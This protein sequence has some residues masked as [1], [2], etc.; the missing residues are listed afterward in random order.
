M[1]DYDA[2]KKGRLVLKGEKSS[3]LKRK[4]KQKHKEK[5]VKAEPLTDDDKIA[6]GGWAKVES[7]KDISGSV[8]I[9]FGKQTYV[10]SL[11]N[12]L[13]NLGAPHN[14]GDAPSPEEV[15]TAIPVSDNKV[16]F[17]SGYGKYLGVSKDGTV[18]GRSDAIG[19]LEQW[20]PVFQDGKMALLANTGCFVSVRDEDDSIVASSR[21]AGSAEMLW[22][23]SPIEKQSDSGPEI[24]AEEKGSLAEIEVNYV[25]KFQKFQDK[26][27]KVSSEQK[28]ALKQAKDKG[29]LHEELLNR[30]SKMKAD[31]YCKI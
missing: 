24:P 2:V 18:I 25:R 6:H 29:T 5:K 15:L 20:E 23:R 27:L 9:E 11:D 3:S 21:T 16:A 19:S 26:K 17:K 7:I 13:F 12:G 31:R 30:R 14:E 1:S 10:T 4:K 8:A 28:A 22:I